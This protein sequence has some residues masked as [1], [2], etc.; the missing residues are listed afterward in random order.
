MFSSELT[1]D[2]CLGLCKSNRR[3]TVND[4]WRGMV[5]RKSSLFMIIN[6]CCL[7]TSG[8]AWLP[9]SHIKYYKE[10]ST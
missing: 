2:Q 7:T 3:F 9:V 5:S 1:N 6:I 4:L 10:K 8:V